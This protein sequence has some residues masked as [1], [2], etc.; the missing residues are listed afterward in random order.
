MNISIILDKRRPNKDG[1]FPVKIR[2][3]DNGKTSH[4]TTKFCANESTFDEVTGVF[5]ML[6]K[7]TRSERMADNTD[8]LNELDQVKDLF[9]KLKAKSSMKVSP[10]RLKEKYLEGNYEDNITVVDC[11]KRFIETKTGSTA[12]IYTSTLRKIEKYYGNKLFFDDINYS[13]LELFEAKL[14]KEPIKNRDGNIRK[15]GLETNAISIHFRNLRAIFNYAINNEYI[16]LNLYPFRRFKIK[17]ENTIKRSVEVEKLRSIFLCQN[18]SCQFAS[19]LSLIIFGL[20][21]INVQ[22][23]YDLEYITETHIG[24]K[25]AKTKKVYNIKLEPEVKELLIKYRGKNGLVFK[26]QY[27]VKSFRTRVNLELKRITD[28][29]GYD[30]ITSYS[31]R[32]SW[33]TVAAELDIPKETIGAALGHSSKSVTDIYIN[34]NQSKVDIANRE[35]LDYIFQKGEYAPKEKEQKEA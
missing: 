20:L 28:L 25:R 9:E 33:A 21:G 30:K 23:L 19:D 2:L 16:P 17:S 31:L 24:Y 4:I 1:D 18:E 3:Y 22:D 32:H 14:K 8:L 10:A 35:V 27:K 13:W 6:D 34:F 11:F 26:D 5:F 29:L 7:N 12:K 15:V